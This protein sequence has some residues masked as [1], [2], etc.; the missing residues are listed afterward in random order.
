MYLVEIK[1]ED[2][3]R[4]GLLGNG[5]EIVKTL[6]DAEQFSGITQAAEKAAWVLVNG[7]TLFPG[8]WEVYVGLLDR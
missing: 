6:A 8:E 4:L 5:G 2:G 1:D 3:E 7:D